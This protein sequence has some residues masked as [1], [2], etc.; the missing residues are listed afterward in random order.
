M[1][2][3][4]THFI[5]EKSNRD[6]AASAMWTNQIQTFSHDDVMKFLVQLE[7]MWKI[8]DRDDIYLSYRIGYENFFTKDELTEDGL[9]V[10]IDITRVESKVKRM[11]ERLCELYHRSD[12]LN[13]MDIEDDNDMKISV[14]INRLLDQVDDAWQIVF[15]H[16]RISERM[17][18]PTY[19]PINPETDPSIF[20]MSTIN[21]IEELNPFQ[22]AVLQTL[23][24]LYQRQIR[25]YK[26]QCC[27]QIKTL[28]GALT[29]AWKPIESIEEYVYGVA[30]KEVQYDLWKNL[31]AR[32][33]GH[34]DLIRH[35]KNTK[36][37]QFPEIK[38]NRHVWSFKNGIFIG[39]E[40]D[41]EKSDIL[42]PHWRASFYTYE[43]NEFK[44]LDQTIVSSKYFDQEF[45]DYSETDWRDIP[46]PYFDSVL[47]YQ[48][49]NKDVCEWIFAMGGRLCFDVNEIDKW[50]CIPFLK[51]VA[52]SGKS[53]LITK[54]F[55]KFYCT[56]D[57]KTLSN[58]V[59]RKFGLSAIMDGF[60]F[61]APEIKGDLALE[62]AEFQSIVSGEDVSIAVK[63]EKAKSF[64]WTVP[65]ILG[66]NEVPNWRDNSGSILRRVLTAD[67]TKQVREA[68][69]TLDAKLEVE[70][71]SILQKC[72]RAYLEFAQKWPEK[73]IWNIV[74]QYFVDVQRQLATSCSPLESF[75]SEPCI[76]FSRDKKC[77]LKFFKKKYSEF[78]GVMNKSLN[79]DIWAGPFGSRDIRVMRIGEPTKY[80]SCDDTFPVMEQ[81]GTEFILGLDIVDM[82]A[83][84]VMSFGTD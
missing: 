32:A 79:Q 68:D 8:N 7:D 31:T 2:E 56:E 63:H 50:Q 81:N 40:F 23:K 13:M 54:V 61:I 78:H 49:F 45:P 75:L 18:N 3:A 83:K 74:P 6:D 71:P 60:M 64:E 41:C 59:E 27:L 35:L 28:D 72:V 51:G 70:L 57:V 62:Q 43:S 84:P 52:R 26:G 21:N 55:R 48:K 19:V 66:G 36:D 39:K 17:N 5:D 20:R 30:K 37:M 14:R 69:P 1:T 9:P 73:D 53:T 10:S 25:R 42:T 33:P 82:S 38:K 67:F 65:G 29:R 24:D 34:N 12:T 22:Q 47:N 11:N 58:N 46:T 16:A 80:Q 15:R 44:N 76:E 77:P 4:V